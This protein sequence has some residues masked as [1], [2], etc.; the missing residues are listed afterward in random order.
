MIL[1]LINYTQKDKIRKNILNFL[2]W[3][4]TNGSYTDKSRKSSGFNIMTFEESI[5]YFFGVINDDI[6]YSAADNIF[7]LSF[8]EVILIAHKNKIYYQTCRKINSLINKIEPDHNFYKTL[9]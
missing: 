9:I 4:D 1:I 8:E 2:Q 3:N 5:K 7:E 6:Y